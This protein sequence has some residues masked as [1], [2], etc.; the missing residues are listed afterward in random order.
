[1][2]KRME[3]DASTQTKERTVQIETM[4]TRDGGFEVLT[5]VSERNKVGAFTRTEP[6]WRSSSTLYVVPPE[7][8]A[9]FMK[10]FS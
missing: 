3:F 4:Q 6:K 2:P 5:K 10:L 1:M 8:V 9:E 7:K